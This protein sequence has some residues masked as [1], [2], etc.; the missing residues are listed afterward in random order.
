MRNAV[1]LWRQCV[2]EGLTI[3]AMATPKSS[4]ETL[5][6]AW[7]GLDRLGERSALRA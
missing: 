6:A 1:T 2:D 4:K 7:R 5:L 3:P